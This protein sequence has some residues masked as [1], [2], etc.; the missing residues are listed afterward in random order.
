MTFAGC[1]ASVPPQNVV[2]IFLTVLLISVRAACQSHLLG[3]CFVIYAGLKETKGH[4]SSNQEKDESGP[5]VKFP[6][7]LYE[8]IKKGKK[9]HCFM[10]N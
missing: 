2:W 5:V 4:L 8:S 9:H 1:S 6:V 7:E 3:D 10:K